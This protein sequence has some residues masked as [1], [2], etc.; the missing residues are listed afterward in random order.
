LGKEQQGRRE[1]GLQAEE[2]QEMQHAQD[3]PVL[4]AGSCSCPARRQLS[5]RSPRETAEEISP[6]LTILNY[7]CKCY[8]AFILYGSLAKP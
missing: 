2:E 7:L 4:N 3:L 1:S 8:Y 5:C 6:V